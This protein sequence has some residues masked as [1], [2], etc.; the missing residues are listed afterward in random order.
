M[1]ASRTILEH[2]IRGVVGFA[3]ILLV[4]LFTRHFRLPELLISLALIGLAIFAW[5]GCPMCWFTGLFDTVVNPRPR[6]KCVSGR[7]SPPL[8]L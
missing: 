7:C 1:F 8:N 5:R 2:L 4:L 3:S 6:S